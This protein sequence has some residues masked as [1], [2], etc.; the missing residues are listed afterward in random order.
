V[1]QGAATK[2]SNIIVTSSKPKWLSNNAAWTKNDAEHRSNAAADVGKEGPATNVLNEDDAA[3]WDAGDATKEQWIMF[4]LRG[5]HELTK[6]EIRHVTTGAIASAVG[7]G[8]G[9]MGMGGAA[10]LASSYCPEV[11]ATPCGVRHGVA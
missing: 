7:G 9:K 5:Y 3:M 11:V 2:T 10:D 1:F 4:D 6:F 8:F